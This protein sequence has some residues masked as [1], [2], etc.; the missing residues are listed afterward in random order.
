M[1]SYFVRLFVTYYLFGLAQGRVLIRIG[2]GIKID[3][4]IRA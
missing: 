4:L 1:R 3:S 2:I